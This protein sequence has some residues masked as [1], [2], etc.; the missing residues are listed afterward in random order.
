MRNSLVAKKILY[1]KVATGLEETAAQRLIEE[2]SKIP[3][4]Q[5]VSAKITLGDAQKLVELKGPDSAKIQNALKHLRIPWRG[6]QSAQIAQILNVIHQP[7]GAPSMTV[8]PD[9]N[10]YFGIN[11]QDFA[12]TSAQS[13]AP[14]L[15]TMVFTCVACTLYS[16]SSKIGVLAHFDD[17]TSERPESYQR[18]LD[19]L[20]SAGVSDLLDLQIGFYG[21][22]LPGNWAG[23]SQLAVTLQNKLQEEIL[24]RTKSLMD[25]SR[26]HSNVRFPKGK[27]KE[28]L[29]DLGFVNRRIALDTRTGEI[30]ELGRFQPGPMLDELARRAEQ[31]DRMPYEA[32]KRPLQQVVIP[33]A[34]GLEELGTA[35]LDRMI[36]PIAAAASVNFHQ[37]AYLVLGPEAFAIYGREVTEFLDRL[38]PRVPA[39]TPFLVLVGDQALGLAGRPG[40]LFAADRLEAA[41]KALTVLGSA[42]VQLASTPEEAQQFESLLRQQGASLSVVPVPLSDLQE[43][44][45]RIL[46]NLAG[47]EEQ[48]SEGQVETLYGVS[49][50]DLARQLQALSQTGV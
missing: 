5:S 43:M 22:E 50:K 40:V 35:D 20:Q 19:A 33:P 38:Q 26:F 39:L 2:M 36:L 30:F 11:Q 41:A 18:I 42:Q 49:L 7:S 25:P 31:F 48:T 10:D 27:E 46:A 45:R 37:P 17:L 28:S 23:S 32:K 15:K 1:Q 9:R 13:R 12:V 21:L 44:L 4:L 16:P 8:Q 34:A 14:V 6:G 24:R 47:L 29:R 3:G